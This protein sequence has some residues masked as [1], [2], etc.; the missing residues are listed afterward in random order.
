MQNPVFDDEN[1]D[2]ILFWDNFGK[3]DM[4]GLSVSI[5]ELP[6]VKWWILNASVFG[7]YNT[8]KD[9]SGTYTNN[10]FMANAY[11]NFTFLLP[12][13]WKIEFGGW[14]QSSTPWGYFKVHPQYAFFGGIKKNFFEDK[15][16]LT[17]N[18]NDIFRTMSSNVDMYDGDKLTYSL[19]QQFNMQKVSVSF[20]YRFGKAKPTRQRNVGNME[21]ASR[22]G[23]GAS[24][25]NSSN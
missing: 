22:V 17:I 25:G 24:I 19:N 13:E 11:A 16:T 3:Q 21:D 23:G 12:K 6:I 20:T 8:N 18:V 9:Y 7:A 5:T 1:G 2:K 15:A 4:A 14:Y 10:G